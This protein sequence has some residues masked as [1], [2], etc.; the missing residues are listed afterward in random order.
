[1]NNNSFNF[2]KN[3]FIIQTYKSSNCIYFKDNVI[4]Y[5]CLNKND[6]IPDYIK[7]LYLEYYVDI[8]R[9]IIYNEVNVDYS[10]E[11]TYYL[12][13][14]DNQIKFNLQTEE[15]L[16]LLLCL[17]CFINNEFDIMKYNNEFDY[18]LISYLDYKC[19]IK[20][21][22]KN[23]LIINTKINL[24]FN[25]KYF[26][27]LFISDDVINN[28]IDIYTILKQQNIIYIDINII[29]KYKLL[30]KVFSSINF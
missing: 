12:K 10:Y 6:K 17:L 14:L 15:H 3:P 9:Y 25:D 20:I 27:Q 5:I 26:I 8:Y 23:K 18:I 19:I 11:F 28:I 22:K 21:D 30:N 2:L 16:I 4:K 13:N 1:M 7:G 24:S 29:I